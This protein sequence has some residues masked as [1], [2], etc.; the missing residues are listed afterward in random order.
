MTPTPT[1]PRPILVDR[2]QLAAGRS[3]IDIEGLPHSA[4]CVYAIQ[5]R[6]AFH[7]QVAK[8]REAEKDRD[9]YKKIAGKPWHWYLMAG[10]VSR[11]GRIGQALVDWADRR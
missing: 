1:G 2:D 4:A 8:T 10:S 9:G 5:M 6:D 11:V 3:D 7:R